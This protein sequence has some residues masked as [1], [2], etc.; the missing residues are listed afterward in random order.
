[1]A[2]P[3]RVFEFDPPMS[4]GR[5]IP[6]INAALEDEGLAIGPSSGTGDKLRAVLI[7]GRYKV[8]VAVSRLISFETNRNL[9]A[10]LGRPAR[11]AGAK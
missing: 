6:A 5:A 10:N 7:D 4:L 2:N 11:P 9:K 1:M 3:E 8:F